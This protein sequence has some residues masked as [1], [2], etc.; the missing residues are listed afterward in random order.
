[1]PFKKVTYLPGGIPSMGGRNYLGIRARI[2][3]T[4]N[5]ERELRKKIAQ[6]KG[7]S[8]AGLF[9]AG[10]MVR[11]DMEVTQPLTPVKTGTMLRQWRAI[12]EPQK[13]GE[14]GLRIGYVGDT[15]KGAYAVYVHEMTEPP[16]D[17]VQWTREGSGPQWFQKALERNKDAM[18]QEIA[19]EARKPLI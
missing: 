2:V 12:P 1:M 10:D 18:L 9:M 16:Y 13:N 11:R 15:K 17:D 8:L 4:R 7:Y 14:P 3:E 19:D 5:I 6:I